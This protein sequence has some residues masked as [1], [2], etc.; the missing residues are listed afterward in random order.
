[1]FSQRNNPY[2]ELLQ[3]NGS[4]IIEIL[5]TFAIFNEIFEKSFYEKDI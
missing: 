3:N 4:N 2:C 5:K 1:M